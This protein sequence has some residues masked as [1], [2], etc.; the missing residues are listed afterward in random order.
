MTAGRKKV[1]GGSNSLIDSPEGQDYYTENDLSTSEN[2]EPSF[3]NV[4]KYMR[5]N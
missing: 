4:L 1:A 2:N 5:I 3:F